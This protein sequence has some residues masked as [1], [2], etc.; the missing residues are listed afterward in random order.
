LRLWLQRSDSSALLVKSPI[1][2]PTRTKSPKHKWDGWLPC[3]GTTYRRDRDEVELLL[4]RTPSALRYRDDME[5]VFSQLR[6]DVPLAVY[7]DMKSPYA[8]LAVAP[9]RAMAAAAGVRI[10]WRPFTLDIPS[11]LGSAKL[12]KRGTAVSSQRTAQQ[13]SGVRYAYMDARRYANLTG[14]IVRGTVKIWDSS[15][16][17][18]AMLWAKGQG[19][20]VLD[21]FLDVAY[22]R[23]WQRDLDVE[24]IG[25]LEEFLRQIGSETS[26]FACYAE[27][28]GRSEHDDL[29]RAA[30]DAGVFGVPSYLVE[31]EMWF[32][33][34]HLPRVAWLLA[35]RRDR[36]PCVAN[37]SF[38][39]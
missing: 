27:G 26:G 20:D 35:G 13:W 22:L 34:E 2:I 9:T 38:D 15:L 3:S 29:N 11:Y 6:G 12:D 30:F 19:D 18:I 17:G 37:R 32:G 16:A 8:Y 39:K 31:N 36:A 23:F 1:A 28:P 24:D 25:V 10:D 33:R 5:G 7:I 4:R 14:K 21:R